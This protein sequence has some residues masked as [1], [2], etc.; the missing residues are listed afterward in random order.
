MYGMFFFL[1]FSC[2]FGSYCRV[3]SKYKK[4]IKPK[5]PKKPKNL[6]NLKTFFKKPRF[7]PALASFRLYLLY[8]PI[9]LAVIRMIADCKFCNCTVDWTVEFET[10]FMLARSCKHCFHCFLLYFLL[11]GFLLF[12]S[13]YNLY[14]A[15]F[16][17]MT[18]YCLQYF[19]IRYV[20]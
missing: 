3:R 20:T 5:K 16:L 12:L 13:L 2:A 17:L 11:R 8:L 4:P 9:A 14:I 1:V 7:F 15:N 19:T 10:S 6:K 18:F